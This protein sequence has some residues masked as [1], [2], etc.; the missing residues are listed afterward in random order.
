MGAGTGLTA[1]RDSVVDHLER[2]GLARSEKR[3]THGVSGL[4][5]PDHGE[6]FTGLAFCRSASD[7][8]LGASPHGK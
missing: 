3:G 4:G 2:R 5:A 1:D 8:G 7:H 6:D